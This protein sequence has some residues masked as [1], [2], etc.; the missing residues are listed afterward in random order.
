MTIFGQT[1]KLQEV[2]ATRK[3]KSDDG[4][5]HR[6]N[7]FVVTIIDSRLGEVCP[8]AVIVAPTT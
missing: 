6:I 2:L 5:L 1:A 4:L 8:A 7:L 3:S